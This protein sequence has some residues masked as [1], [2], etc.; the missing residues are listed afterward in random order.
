MFM[1]SR[2]V[3]EELAMAHSKP[4]PFVELSA[5]FMER[6]PHRGIAVFDAIAK[7]PN[8]QVLPRTRAWKQYSDL[9]TS[10]F[11]AVW[12]GADAA[13]EMARVQAR[14]Q[15]LIDDAAAMARARA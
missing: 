9:I 8:V 7:S 4:S 5:G 11:D 14:A 2:D 1:Q 15:G 13:G 6:H 3:Q 12:G 10:A